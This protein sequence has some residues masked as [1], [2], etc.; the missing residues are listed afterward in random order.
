MGPAFSRAFGNTTAVFSINGVSTSAVPIILRN[1][2]SLDES[3]QH[4]QGVE[5][6]TY[7]LAVAASDVPGLASLRD[8]MIFEGV[9]YAITN[10]DDD[11]RAML[12][13]YVTGDI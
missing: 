2:R 9:T 1:G 5:A 3:E 4:D 11:G 6:K 8:S 10:H 12:R 7:S 13:L